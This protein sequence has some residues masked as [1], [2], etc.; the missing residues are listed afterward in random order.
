M[1][2]SE[3]IE[4]DLDFHNAGKKAR[5]LSWKTSALFLNS[6]R[7][8]MPAVLTSA[9]FFNLGRALFLADQ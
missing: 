8:K 2:I 7:R 6:A 4:L 1:G 5:L 9:V 3:R